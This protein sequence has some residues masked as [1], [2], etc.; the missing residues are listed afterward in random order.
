VNIFIRNRFK[1]IIF[2]PTSTGKTKT[3]NTKSLHYGL[4]L[5]FMFMLIPFWINLTFGSEA[6][7]AA[8]W[9]LGLIAVVQIII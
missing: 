8:N 2:L 6:E 5:L 1:N 9:L 7:K 4:I 3:L